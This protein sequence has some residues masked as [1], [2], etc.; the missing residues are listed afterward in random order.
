MD[1]NIQQ[2]VHPETEWALW[3][4]LGLG[5]ITFPL[6]RLLSKLLV[7]SLGYYGASEAS[8]YVQQ[9]RFGNYML[10]KL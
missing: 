4:S 6:L 2:Q 3:Y 1:L 7:T 5:N 8:G 10:N 9:N